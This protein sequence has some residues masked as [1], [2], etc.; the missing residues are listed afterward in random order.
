M[1]VEFPYLL[2]QTLIYSV[3]V[4]ATVQFEWRAGM[5]LV[6]VMNAA[7]CPSAGAVWNSMPS[8]PGLQLHGND[9]PFFKC[10]A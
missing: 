2:A 8:Q 9:G 5:H 6:P 7:Q 1:L 4:Y 10:Y 3:I